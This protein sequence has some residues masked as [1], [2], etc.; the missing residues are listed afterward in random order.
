MAA[1][2]RLYGG[3]MAA[4]WRLCGG[5][6]GEETPRHLAQ[7]AQHREVDPRQAELRL[8]REEVG[9]L[10]PGLRGVLGLFFVCCL[11]SVDVIKSA[12]GAYLEVSSSS[13]H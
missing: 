12:K 8:V 1:A 9:L 3:C 2:W 4:V 13:K 11:Y 10:Q 5:A 7:P 6:E